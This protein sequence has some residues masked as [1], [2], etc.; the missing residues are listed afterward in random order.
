MA[1]FDQLN[2][3]GDV[4]PVTVSVA[5]PFDWPHV[6]DVE[7]AETV[8]PFVFETLAVAEAVHPFADVTVTV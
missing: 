3:Y 6:A 2:V 8:G 1:P 5:A 4:P 7:L